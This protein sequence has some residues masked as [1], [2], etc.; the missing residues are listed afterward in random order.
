MSNGSNHHF[1]WSSDLASTA[2]GV[3]IISLLIVTLSSSLMAARGTG[4]PLRVTGISDGIVLTIVPLS[5]FTETA[6][7]SI[8]LI[9][10]L[11]GLDS[12]LEP[13][14]GISFGEADVIGVLVR[15]DWGEAGVVWF[16]ELVWLDGLG[17]IG[18]TSGPPAKT[19]E[20]INGSRKKLI[21]RNEKKKFW[22][23]IVWFSR[24]QMYKYCIPYILWN[25][26]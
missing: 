21:K 9:V 17:D 4:L 13:I 14:T 7:P 10:P 15:F 12:W 23:V 20:L 3:P 16:N 24:Q 22:R 1:V 26:N 18:S 8:L 11:I 25:I 2:V 5:V 6:F 19:V